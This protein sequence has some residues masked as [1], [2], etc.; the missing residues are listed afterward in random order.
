[1]NSGNLYMAIDVGTTKVCTLIAQVSPDGEL[2]IVG[3]GVEPSRGMRKGLVVDI[4][5]MKAAVKDSVEQASSGLGRDLPG[6]CIGVT[7]AHI[8]S[9]HTS[10]K[11]EQPERGPYKGHYPIRDGL[12]GEAVLSHGRPLGRSCS[13]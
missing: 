7:G 2:E 8:F 1:M 12:G 11:L 4:E 3:T 13:T 10:G 5:E 9:V 6:A